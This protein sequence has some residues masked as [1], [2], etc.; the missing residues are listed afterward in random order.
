VFALP[1]PAWDEQVEQ[2][3][4][5]AILVISLTWKGQPLVNYETVVNLIGATKTSGGLRV[6]ALL[7]TN[8]YETGVK[9]TKSQ[10]ESLRIRSA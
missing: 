3:R 5:P 1:L 10:M 9:I 2:N 8:E 6:K 7:D 4:T